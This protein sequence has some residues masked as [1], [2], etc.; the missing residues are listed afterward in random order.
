MMIPTT[1]IT[2]CIAAVQ[3]CIQLCSRILE[4][5]MLYFRNY[6]Q[7][8]QYHSAD[9]KKHAVSHKCHPDKSSRF[10]HLR[11]VILR[12]LHLPQLHSEA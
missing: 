5:S 4:P 6:S 2:G 8:T 10:R 11:H 9:Q 7:H 1:L 3:N 12:P